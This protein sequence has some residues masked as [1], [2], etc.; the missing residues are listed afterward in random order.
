M[1]HILCFGDSNTYGFCPTGGR[2][3]DETRWTRVLARLLGP[4]YLV[5]EE[6][7]NSRTTALDDP[8]EPYRNAMDYIVPCLQSHAPLDLTI[9]MLGTNDLK[10]FFQPTADKIAARLHRLTEVILDISQAPVLLVSPVSLGDSA[11][12]DPCALLYP[13]HSVQVSRELGAVL[14]QT[15]KELG[16]PFM[17]ASDYVSADPL[18]HVHLSAESHR[19]L[20]RAFADKIREI[21][22]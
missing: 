17:D 8:F 16:V 14:E 7:L 11:P 21:G 18:D 9:L 20:A 5:L 6:G 4:E 2:Y 10:E 1:K 13:P 12:G 15:A 3:D 19:L 22:I